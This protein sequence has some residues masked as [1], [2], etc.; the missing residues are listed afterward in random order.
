MFVI[1]RFVQL[2]KNFRKAAVPDDLTGKILSKTSKRTAYL[3]QQTQ[4]KRRKI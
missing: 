4:L 1:Y 3:N 2:Q